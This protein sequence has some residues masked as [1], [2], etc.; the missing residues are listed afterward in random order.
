MSKM[1]QWKPGDEVWAARFW[2]GSIKVESV[3]VARAGRVQ[4][5]LQDYHPA[6]GYVKRIWVDQGAKSRREALLVLKAATAVELNKAKSDV[7]EAEARL[8]AVEVA[9]MK[10]DP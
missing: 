2:G 9:L 4:L 3:P 7:L 8:A 6:M 1:A 10:E 5:T